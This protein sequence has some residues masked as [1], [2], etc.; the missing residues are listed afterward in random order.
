MRCTNCGSLMM[1]SGDG[2]YECGWVINAP[3]FGRDISPTVADGLILK[4]E[5]GFLSLPSQVIIKEISA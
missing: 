3:H 5:A 4:D 1:N 2:E